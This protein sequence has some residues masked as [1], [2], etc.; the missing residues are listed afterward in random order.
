MI[1]VDAANVRYLRL[2]P[3]DGLADPFEAYIDVSTL[4]PASPMSTL[5]SAS[6]I[7]RWEKNS[8]NKSSLMLQDLFQ[9]SSASA[10]KGLPRI[11]TFCSDAFE[12]YDISSSLSFSSFRKPL[13]TVCLQT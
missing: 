13:N 3:E 2:G 4:Q 10:I 8:G 6:Q 5:R 1:D 7:P 11:V 12:A 9:D